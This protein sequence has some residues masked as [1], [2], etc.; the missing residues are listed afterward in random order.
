MNDSSD[1]H[2]LLELLSKLMRVAHDLE[3][4][5]F[6]LNQFFDNRVSSS[7]QERIARLESKVLYLER[8]D[9]HDHTL[10]IFRD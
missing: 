3:A 5:I 10:Q 9:N 8:R 6:N 7:S 1:S 4:A 2:E